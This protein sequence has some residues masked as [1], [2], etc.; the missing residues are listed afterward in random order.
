MGRSSNWGCSV[1]RDILVLMKYTGHWPMG[2]N[3]K[4]RRYEV[5]SDSE[6]N[7]LLR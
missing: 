7:V 6:A 5:T 3:V 1:S 4:G 2:V